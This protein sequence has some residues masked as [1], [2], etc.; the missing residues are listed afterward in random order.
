MPYNPYSHGV[1]ERFHKTIKDTLC[2]IHNDDLENFDIRERLEIVIKK[3][4]N[5][6]HSST[7]Y[8]PIG[9]LLD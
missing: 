7:K 3:Y 8:T 1:V 4:N 2:Y 5:Y 9:F 6:I